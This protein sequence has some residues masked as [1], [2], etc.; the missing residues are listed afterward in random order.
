M[1]SL[2]VASDRRGWIVDRAFWVRHRDPNGIIVMIKAAIDEAGAHRGA[3]ALVVAV[4]AAEVDRWKRMILEWEEI[5]PADY[6]AKSAS[7]ETNLAL[8]E[9]MRKY[10]AG[11]EDGL[12]AVHTVSEAIFKKYASHRFQSQYGGPYGYAATIAVLDVTIWSREV[13]GGWADFVIEDGHRGAPYMKQVFG[14]IMGNDALRREFGVYQ[15]S[16]VGKGDISVHPADLLSHDQR[17]S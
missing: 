17:T 3:P 8:A 7:D 13:G 12:A 9:I 10:L 16:W 4:C 11:P 1:T 14:R 2:S 15:H 6:H 5:A